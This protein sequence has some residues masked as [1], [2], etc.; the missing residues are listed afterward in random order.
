MGIGSGRLER[1][2]EELRKELNEMRKTN[3]E[4]S[5]KNIEEKNTFKQINDSNQKLIEELKKQ[6]NLYLEQMK[7]KT[8]EFKLLV[9]ETRLIINLIISHSNI[10]DKNILKELES[11]LKNQQDMIKDDEKE[12]NISTTIKNS[13]NSF[14]F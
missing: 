8:K 1:Q 14:D 4:Q 5:K 11:L 9:T 7:Q 3:E 10:T 13:H 12:N 6:N 2:I